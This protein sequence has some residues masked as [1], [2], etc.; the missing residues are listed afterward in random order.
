MLKV[1]DPQTARSSFLVRQSLE[2]TPLSPAVQ[3]SILR[4]FGEV[5][6]PAQV[7]ERILKDVRARGDDALRDWTVKLDGQSP[8][9]LSLIHI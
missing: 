3:A 5:L 4:L 7:V 2:D 8:E 9:S 1:Y 6:T